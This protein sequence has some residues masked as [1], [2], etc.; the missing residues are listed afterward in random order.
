MKRHQ[1]AFLAC[2]RLFNCLILL[3]F[4]KNKQFVFVLLCNLDVIKPTVFIIDEHRISYLHRLH[5]A[6]FDFI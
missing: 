3:D 6:K 5:F 1:L 2:S 4:L